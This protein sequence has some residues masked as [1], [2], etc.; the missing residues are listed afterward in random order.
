[1][2]KLYT[3]PTLSA[4]RAA[5]ENIPEGLQELFDDV[6]VTILAQDK[7]ETDLAKRVLLWI[8]RA[9]RPLT[10]LELQHALA[11]EVGDKK[12]DLDAL[13]DEVALVSVC[14]GLITVNDSTK[15]VRFVRMYP[16]SCCHIIF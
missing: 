1:M 2:A 15:G 3:K 11:V 16:L 6:W 14:A 7:A 9:N 12:V 13:P 10:T 4:V 5:L 8:S